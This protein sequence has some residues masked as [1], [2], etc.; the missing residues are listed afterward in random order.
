MK[1]KNIL[2]GMWNLTVNGTIV[3]N[4]IYGVHYFGEDG[5]YWPGLTGLSHSWRLVNTSCGMRLITFT[6][7]SIR[8]VS[9]YN[10][11]ENNTVLTI[12]TNVYKKTS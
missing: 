7:S 6:M 4:E 1:E 10:L 5:N 2:I 3:G 12:G 11:S 9:S 8:F